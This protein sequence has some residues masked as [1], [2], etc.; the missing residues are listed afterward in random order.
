MPRYFRSTTSPAPRRCTPSPTGSPTRRPR[1]SRRWPTR[2]GLHLLRAAPVDPGWSQRALPN[3]MNGPKD[4]ERRTRAP[5]TISTQPQRAT[6]RTSPRARLV[7]RRADRRVQPRIKWRGPSSTTILDL[8]PIRALMGRLRASILP[9]TCDDAAE[10]PRPLKAVAPVR[11]RSGVPAR[12]ALTSANADRSS[13][14]IHGALPPFEAVAPVPIRRGTKLASC[15]D[16]RKRCR[17]FSALSG[18]SPNGTGVTGICAHYVPRF[19]RHEVDPERDGDRRRGADASGQT[20]EAAERNCGA[21][22]PPI[23]DVDWRA[24]R[25]RARHSVP[26]LPSLS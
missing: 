15:P 2:R 3:T 21:A 16:Q 4:A 11:I 20:W 23:T 6:W 22:A 26:F 8:C 5:Q 7:P 24:D 18:C 13:F 19:R 9:L 10:L 12:Q 1:C 17:D 25:L 14:A